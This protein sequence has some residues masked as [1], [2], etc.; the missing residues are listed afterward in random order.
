MDLV[1]TYDFMLERRLKESNSDLARRYTCCTA[2]FE[3]VLKKFFATFPTFTDHTLLHTLS[4][5]NLANRLLRENVNK[6]NPSEIYIYL[7]SA[8]LHDVGM[9]VPVKDIDD[10][11]DAAGIRDY[12]NDHAEMSAP[13]L[14]R[15]FHHDFSAA[16]VMKYWRF[17]EIPSDKYADAI[18]R[19]GRGHRK[20]DLMDETLYPTDYDLGD[21]GKAN[22]AALAAVIR[23]A[24]ELDIASDRNPDLL[25][26]MESMEG[27]SRKDVFE[28]SKHHSIRPIVFKDQ[29]VHVCADTEDN[30]I[31]RGVI[32]CVR[33]V[34]ETLAYCISVLEK[35]STIRIQYAK[36]ELKLNGQAVKV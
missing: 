26:D 9:G 20:T 22:L 16:F 11:I 10:Y 4:V 18:A 36:V 6:L 28:F 23:I 14:I 29:S 30:E 15:K 12:V 8:A 31:A 33:T 19:V 34:K 25:Y 7:M 32:E 24:D 21:G 27:M 1:P 3:Q 13:A 2:V 35:R 5:I 17:L